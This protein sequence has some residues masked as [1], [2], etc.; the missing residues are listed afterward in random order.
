MTGSQWLV[1]QLTGFDQLGWIVPDL[2]WDVDADGV[3]TD[4]DYQDWYSFGPTFDPMPRQGYYADLTASDLM[5]GEQIAA[6]V[7]RPVHSYLVD[8]GTPRNFDRGELPFLVDSFGSPVLYWRAATAAEPFSEGDYLTE[9]SKYSHW[10][11]AVVLGSLN[12]YDTGGENEGM[13]LGSGAAANSMRVMGWDA[14]ARRDRP[15]PGTFCGKLYDPVKYG[16]GAAIVGTVIPRHTT[17][18][19]LYSPGPDKLYGTADDIANFR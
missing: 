5:T 2:Q 18:F 10:D 6:N 1:A 16:T 8:Q 12:G 13:D 15:E 9:P 17:G 3:L 14:T 11:N 19:I 7:E 4:I